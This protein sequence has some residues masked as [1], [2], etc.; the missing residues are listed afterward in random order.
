VL[1]PPPRPPQI[2]NPLL[3]RLTKLVAAYRAALRPRLLVPVGL[4][5][6][7]GLYNLLADEP[8]P[9]VYE[10]CALGGFLSYKLALI[11]KLV[12]D[13]TPKVN[14]GTCCYWASLEPT[15]WVR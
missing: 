3:R 5:A 2:E 6:L 14:V 1:T 13:L 12:D 9:L 4:A 7:V 8:L 11:F 10:G 15:T